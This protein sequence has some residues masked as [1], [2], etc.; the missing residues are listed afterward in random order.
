MKTECV[1]TDGEWVLWASG[2]STVNQLSAH[3]VMC[4]SLK[5]TTELAGR[6]ICPY[7]TGIAEDRRIKNLRSALLA[8]QGQSGYM[9]TCQQ[10]ERQSI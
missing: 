9:G 7:S 8:Y 5:D 1:D 3:T 6:G 10:T 4:A 2:H